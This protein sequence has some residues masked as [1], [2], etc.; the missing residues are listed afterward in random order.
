MEKTHE[1]TGGIYLVID[2]CQPINL[3]LQKLE[4]ALKGGV[5]AVQIW[6]NWDKKTDKLTLVEAIGLLCR[7]YQVPLFINDEWQLLKQTLF[8][9]GVHFDTIP[10]DYEFI[11]KAVTRS[12]MAGITCSGDLNT[13]AWASKHQLNYVSFCAMF[14]SPSAGSCSIVVPSVVKEAHETTSLPLFVS[15]GITPQNII[16]LKEKTPFDG[17]A[18]ISGI[19]SA[20]DPQ[21]QV[22]IYKDALGIAPSV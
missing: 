1:I 6:N 16:T 13:V 8:L 17:V 3:L 12:F 14:P 11:K 21:K 4:S 7:K 20:N 5:N 2:P 19:M 9:D 18:V 15:G 10:N 22:K